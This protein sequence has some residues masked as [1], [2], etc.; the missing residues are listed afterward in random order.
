MTLGSVGEEALG[1]NVLGNFLR[2][3]SAPV[4]N[5]LGQVA[6]QVDSVVVKPLAEPPQYRTV[7]KEVEAFSRNLSGENDLHDALAHVM[8]LKN[9]ATVSG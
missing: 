4:E 1:K 5:L 3:K 9:P 8:T 6:K 2:G 7:A